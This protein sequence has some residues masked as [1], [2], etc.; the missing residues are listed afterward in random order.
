MILLVQHHQGTC[1]C[2]MGADFCQG[3]LWFEQDV[4]SSTITNIVTLSLSHSFRNSTSSVICSY[5]DMVAFCFP[6]S[7][8]FLSTPHSK[9]PVF[10][11]Y[12]KSNC[13]AHLSITRSVSVQRLPVK[14]FVSNPTFVFSIYGLGTEIDC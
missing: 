8:D 2:G 7:C 4:G 12:L 10:L 6:H 11:G 9:L 3:L 13:T 5:C 1:L 14:I